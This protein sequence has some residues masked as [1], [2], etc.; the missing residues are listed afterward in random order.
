[1]RFR[2]RWNDDNREHL[3]KHDVEPH[4]AQY[5]VEHARPPYPREFGHGKYGVWGQTRQDRYLQVI[6]I[7]VSEDEIDYEELRYEELVAL[8]EDRGPLVYVIH[9]RDLTDAEK[10][11]HRRQ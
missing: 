8:M 9:A 1:M 11:R 10:R 7:H 5:I 4:E 6:Y 3:T 2:F